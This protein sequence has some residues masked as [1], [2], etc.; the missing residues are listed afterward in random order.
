MQ[1][2]YAEPCLAVPLSSMRQ[3]MGVPDRAEAGEGSLGARSMRPECSKRDS[4]KLYINF[5][6]RPL[7]PANVLGLP[8]ECSV[9]PCDRTYPKDPVQVPQNAR[10]R[11]FNPPRPG[12]YM[13]P[14]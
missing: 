12:V 14:R 2:E 9:D 10:E 13:V 6:Q 4:P 3:L 1:I 7:E 11:G 8:V 5:Y